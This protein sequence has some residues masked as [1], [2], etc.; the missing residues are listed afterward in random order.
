MEKFIKQYSYFMKLGLKPNEASVIS[1][2]N[3]RMNLSFGNKDFYDKKEHAYFVIF[4]REDLAKLTNL[5]ECTI[6]RILIR[7]DKRKILKKKSQFNAPNKYFLPKFILNKTHALQKSRSHVAKSDNNHTDL[8]QTDNSLDNTVNTEN[9]EFKT[10]S[11][12]KSWIE[13]TKRIGFT[14]TTL[15]TIAKFCKH[16]YEECYNMVDKI[17]IARNT[18]VNKYGLKNKNITSFETNKNIVNGLGAKLQHI[19]S[20]ITRKNFKSYG[21]YVVNS[22]KEFFT[23]CFG[24]KPKGKIIEPSKTDHRDWGII[25][26]GNGIKNIS[27]LKNK[28]VAFS[29]LNND[30]NSEIEK[31]RDIDLKSDEFKD[32]NNLVQSLKDIRNNISKNIDET[33]VD[34]K[35]NSNNNRPFTPCPMNYLDKDTEEYKNT[36]YIYDDMADKTSYLSIKNDLKP[37]AQIIADKNNQIIEQ[38]EKIL[39]IG[40]YRKKE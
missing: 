28:Y 24:L 6:S 18:I 15:K 12:I 16:N 19:F 1:L 9:S 20:T 36:K 35:D 32:A 4:L 27:G 25:D 10:E 22:L 3:D 33:L 7:L 29:Q 40:K 39:G 13:D 14:E 21:G 2:I 5:A 11:D 23:E 26:Y 34:I 37:Y 38:R 17:K 30:I 31:F 8:S